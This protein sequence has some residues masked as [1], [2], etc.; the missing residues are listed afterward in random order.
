ML[1]FNKLSSHSKLRKVVEKS[2]FPHKARTWLDQLKNLLIIMLTR[3]F[4]DSPK[5]LFYA[6]IDGLFETIWLTQTISIYL[7]KFW[8]I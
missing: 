5:K 2:D 3:F 8:L 4:V 1:A 6:V 7:T